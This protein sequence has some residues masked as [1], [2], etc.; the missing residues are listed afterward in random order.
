VAENIDCLASF[1]ATIVKQG[2]LLTAKHAEYC[3]EL[4][5]KVTGK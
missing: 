1:F 5:D 4:I 3:K 2:V